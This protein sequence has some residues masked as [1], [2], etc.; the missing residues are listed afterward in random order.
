[1]R[2]KKEALDLKPDMTTDSLQ[3]FLKDI[4]KVRLLT[5]QE[6]VDLAKRI[7]RGDLDGACAHL[8]AARA[9][10]SSEHQIKSQLGLETVAL[11]R[12]G[13]HRRDIGPADATAALNALQTMGNASPWQLALAQRWAAQ[14]D[15]AMR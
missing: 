3:L 12:C 1:R 9:S 14:C 10:R 4:G 11:A 13:C 5:A 15:E 6:E 2:R 7:E 8:D